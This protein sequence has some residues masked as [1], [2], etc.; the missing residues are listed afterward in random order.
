MLQTVTA[1]FHLTFTMD[2]KIGSHPKKNC[3]GCPEVNDSHRFRWKLNTLGL[4]MED[5]AEHG[6]WE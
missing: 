4:P 2:M 6:T 5:F 1:M 3:P